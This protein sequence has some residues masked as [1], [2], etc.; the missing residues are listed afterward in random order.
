MPPPSMP[1]GV[2]AQRAYYDWTCFNKQMFADW[3]AWLG[4]LLKQHGVKAPTHTK[5]MVFQTLDR[6]KL[7]HGVDPEL[8]CRATDLAGCDAYAFMGGAYAYDWLRARVLLRP[9]PLVPR[10]RRVQQREP[11]HPGQRNR[12]PHPDEPHPLGPVAGRAAPP[13]LDDHL[14]LGARGGSEPGGQHLFPA[15]ERLWRGAGDARSQSPGPGGGGA[16][17]RQAPRGAALLAAVDLLGGEA[18]RELFA[19]STR[20]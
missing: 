4:S 12:L 16:Q 19:R 13:G 18:T 2:P 15:G 6:D 10:A 1:A 7:A 11:C 20:C 9:A 5:I 8:M 14:G 3:H 17:R